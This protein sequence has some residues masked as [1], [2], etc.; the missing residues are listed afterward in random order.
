MY[1]DHRGHINCHRG[2]RRKCPGNM[3]VRG[4]LHLAILKVVKYEPTYGSEIQRILREKFMIDAP[5]AMVYGLWPFTE[6][7]GAWPLNFD[8]GYERERPC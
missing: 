6:V 4:L 7:G 1:S 8:L 5:R 3:P 2:M